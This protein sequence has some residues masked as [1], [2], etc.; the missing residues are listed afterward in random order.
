M[1]YQLKIVMNDEIILLATATTVMAYENIRHIAETYAPPRHIMEPMVPRMLSRMMEAGVGEE[2]SD[3]W[4]AAAGNH[5]LMY[6]ATKIG[7]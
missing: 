2:F 3:R 7:F 4:M 1:Q 5:R 6:I